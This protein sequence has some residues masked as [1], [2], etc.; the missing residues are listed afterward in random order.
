MRRHGTDQH[1]APAV[2][3][4]DCIDV[5]HLLAMGTRGGIQC[6]RALQHFVGLDF[7]DELCRVALSR[8]VPYI[9][10]LKS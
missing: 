9:C 8:L 4:S 7:L 2:H 3:H 6:V 5:A 10:R 1:Q